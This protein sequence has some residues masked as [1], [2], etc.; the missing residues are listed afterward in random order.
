MIKLGKLP[1]AAGLLA[2]CLFSCSKPEETPKNNETPQE[3]PSQDTEKPVIKVSSL[4]LSAA[5]GTYKLDCTIENPAK[6]GVLSASVSDADWV[7]SVSADGTTL[8]VTVTDNLSNARTATLKLSY[9]GADSK[10]VTLTQKQ[11]VF[12]EFGISMSNLGPFGATFSISRNSGYTGGY[13]FEVLDLASFQKYVDGE[14][15]AIGSFDYADAV[16]Q[17][18]VAYLKRLAQSHGH[19]LTDLFTMIPGMYSKEA[20]VTIPYTSLSV[21]SDYM[22]LVYGMEAS[23][24]AKRRTPICLFQFHTG[25]SSASGLTFNGKVS[26]IA[27]TYASFTITPSNNNEYWYMDWVSEIQ[28]KTK[29]LADVMQNSINNAKSLLSRYEASEILCHGPE[30]MQATEL[31]PGTKYYVVAWGMDLNMEATTEPVVALEFTTTAYDVID[32]CTFQIETLA[33]E[34]MDIKVRVTPSKMDTRYYVAF[35]E[36]SK[37]EGY[38]NEQAAQRIIDMEAQRIDN[39]YYDVPNLSWDNLP[40]LE[41]GIREI[42]GRRDEGWTFSPRHTYIIYVFGID[43]LGI[44]TTNVETIKVTTAEPGVS[45][46][47]FTV[48]VDKVNWQGLDFT[49]TP[50]IQDEYWMSF[51]APASDVNSY[52]RNA[53]GSLKEAELMEWIEEYY[54]DEILYHSFSGTRTL[55]EHVTPETNYILLVFGYAGTYTTEMYE[56]EIYAPAP[57]FNTSEADYTYTVELFRG[58]DLS[59]LDP[60]QFPA[61]DFNGD[62]IMV[63]RLTPNE[64]A[65]HWCFGVWPPKENF[66]DSGGKYHI[67]TLDLDTNVPGSSMQDK[68]FFRTRPW[69]YGCGTSTGEKQPWQDDEGN[70][71]YYYPWTLSGWAE[72]ADGNYGSWHYD[73]LIPIPK[74]KAEVDGPYEMGYTEAYNF[75]SSP[76]SNAGVKIYSVTTGSEINLF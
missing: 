4:E 6:D 33:I 19:S 52:F 12:P 42:W 47:H 57:P 18:D 15:N 75:W 35:V 32:D 21:D 65:A 60:V 3:K 70:V 36:E 5:A 1:L 14:T 30:T 56:W 23:E 9:T 8:N 17:S 39:N 63:V 58:E 67:M 44:R 68:K 2:V 62:C 51:L 46:N 10:D 29:T 27:E 71:M 59:A 34:D 7:T 64:H 74:P 50:E 26:D 54:E 24:E 31:M 13:F 66:R 53:N 16:Y 28:L 61:V 25:Y 11:W 48:T 40:G 55:Y 45:Q 43:N 38:T 76:S 49:V 20:S 37:M 72:D 22:F 69:W 73:Y 41:A